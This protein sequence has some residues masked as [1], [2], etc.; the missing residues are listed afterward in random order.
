MAGERKAARQQI[1]D[2]LI[3]GNI[4]YLDKVFTSPPLRLDWAA[5]AQD[6]EHQSQM[7]IFIDEEGELRMSMGGAT[8]GKKR[9][10][11]MVSMEFY[12]RSL[13]INPEVAQDVF[14]D[15]VDDIK[16][17]LRADRRLGIS[18]SINTDGVIW[19]AGEGGFGIQIDFKDPVD[20]N[21]GGEPI[22]HYAR[23]RFEVTIW[24]TA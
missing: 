2:W 16:A 21:V 10:D 7:V 19:Q 6:R 15:I 4:R 23:I 9:I 17:R 11:Y 3:A 8:S 14:D 1:A 22:E 5:Y 20:G 24:I 12:Y 13:Q 18:S